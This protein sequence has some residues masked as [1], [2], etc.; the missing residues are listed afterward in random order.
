M[1]FPSLISRFGFG[2]TTGSTGFGAGWLTGLLSFFPFPSD[3]NA[4]KYM[5]IVTYTF[6]YQAPGN[7][8]TGSYSIYTKH[9]VR[10][11]SSLETIVLDKSWCLVNISY[12]STK[13]Y[14]EGIH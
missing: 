3:F 4:L 6:M 2:S 11:E 8:F 7:L 14:V 9:V 1:K 13:T 5:H 10:Q 12:Y